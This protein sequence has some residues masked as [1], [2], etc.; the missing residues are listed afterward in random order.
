MNYI[1]KDL[2]SVT[3]S[4]TTVIFVFTAFVCIKLENANTIHDIIAQKSLSAIATN[5]IKSTL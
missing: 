2:I 3:I 1:E 4:K 5:S